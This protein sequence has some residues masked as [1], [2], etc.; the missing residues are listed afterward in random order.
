[1]T[2]PLSPEISKA[3]VAAR[4]TPTIPILFASPAAPL[5]LPLLPIVT[6][7]VNSLSLFCLCFNRASAAK[8][9]TVG[10][11]VCGY[12][13]GGRREGLKAK[14]REEGAAGY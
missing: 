4:T 14:A 12:A 13:L 3:P 1:M 5:L 7:R 6:P 11:H 9:I 8:A 2:P 10:H